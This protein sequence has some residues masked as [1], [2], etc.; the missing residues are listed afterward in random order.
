MV[1]G[2]PRGGVLVA[3]PIAR[4][5]DGELDVALA[6]KIG[7]PHN[8]ELAIGAVGESGDPFL[9]TD[10]I[11]T[12][13][14]DDDFI[15]AATE[16]ARNELARRAV[17]YRGERPAPELAG[18]VVIVV[19]DGIA[20]GA[21]LRA[22]LL[23]VRQQSPSLLVCAVPVGPPESV[24]SIAED[25]DAMVCPLRPRWFRAVGEWYQVFGQ[26]SDEEVIATLGW[27]A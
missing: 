21:T 24:A 1:L 5:L 26:T 7:A 8:P 11:R 10:L 16:L 17:L 6:R 14:V 22:T 18:R 12:L 2:V 19:D 20:T 23:T 25:V 4:S 3:A 27:T 13:G 15:A 9:S